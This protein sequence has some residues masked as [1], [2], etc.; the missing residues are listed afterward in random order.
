MENVGLLKIEIK[1]TTNPIIIMS[2]CAPDTYAWA[3][4]TQCTGGGQLCGIGSLSAVRSV[5]GD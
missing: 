2:L 4:V 1:T 5:H 3:Y